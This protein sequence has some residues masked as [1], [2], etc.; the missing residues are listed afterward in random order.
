GSEE[1]KDSNDEYDHEL[2]ERLMREEM[3]R[4]A[5]LE[6]KTQIKPADNVYFDE[7][8]DHDFALHRVDPN[9]SITLVHTIA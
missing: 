1:E 6:G 9:N 7:E 3:A 5:K 4:L 8:V 2:H